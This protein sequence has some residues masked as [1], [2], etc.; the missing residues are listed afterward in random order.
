MLNPKNS[1]KAYSKTDV[2][3][4]DQ[5]TLIIM[6]YDGLLRFLKKAIVKI[7]EN[8]VEAAHNYFVRSKDIVN[9][10][11]STLHAEKGG[12]IGNNLRELYLYMFRRIVEANLKKDIEITKDG[13]TM[14]SE[15]EVNAKMQELKDIDDNKPNLKASAKAKLIAGEKLTEEEAN[16][17]VGV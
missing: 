16:I 4:S 1:Y 13:A 6:L 17:L 3:T 2:N 12:D 5:L 10:L 9:E 7:E 15:T 14:P 11:L 8:D